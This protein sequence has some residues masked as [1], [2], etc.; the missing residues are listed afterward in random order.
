MKKIIAALLLCMSSC[1]A[2]AA[3]NDGRYRSISESCGTFVRDYAK[4]GSGRFQSEAWVDGYVN[5]YNRFIPDTHDIRGGVDRPSIMLWINNYCSQ[6]PLKNL[7]D[8]M[9]AL[10]EEL[11]P[12]RYRAP[13]R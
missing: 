12:R 3:G 6:N 11:H 7:D 10:V 4:G 9:G 1:P 13:Q 2:T 8:A 5:A